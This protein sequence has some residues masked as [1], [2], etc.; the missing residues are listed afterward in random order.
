MSK[1][2]ILF[3]CLAVTT[4]AIIWIAF[5]MPAVEGAV[6]TVIND[7]SSGTLILDPFG[8]VQNKDPVI[9]L[10]PD[11]SPFL[12]NEQITGSYIKGADVPVPS[13]ST[14]VNTLNMN[15]PFRSCNTGGGG[16]QTWSTEA[17]YTIKGTS[18]LSKLSAGNG[19]QPLEIKLDINLVPQASV[20]DINDIIKATID[21]GN[22]EADLKVNNDDGL[23]TECNNIAGN[24]P[25]KDTS[26]LSAVQQV[27]N[28]PPFRQCLADSTPTVHAKYTIKFGNENIDNAVSQGNKDVEIKLHNDLLDPVKGLSG[29]LSVDGNNG[30][31]VGPFNV[32]SNCELLPT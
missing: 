28:N 13:A 6:A 29:Q 23:M 20:T 1:Q 10:N 4:I 24:V 9:L 32:E 16:K 3:L 19:P 26:S 15:P 21:Y 22:K 2:N 8:H 11:S 14:V 30:V 12:T 5:K 7:T 25:F 27:Q 31:D 18:D 17:I